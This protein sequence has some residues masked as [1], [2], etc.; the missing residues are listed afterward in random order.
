MARRYNSPLP[1]FM[2]RRI[3]PLFLSGTLLV[4]CA[5]AVSEGKVPLAE[6]ARIQKYPEPVVQTKAQLDASFAEWA[7]AARNPINFRLS[8]E[9]KNQWRELISESSW[10]EY[11]RRCTTAF[12]DTGQV[13][14]T[15]EYRD[16]VRL[17]A[18]WRDAAFRSSLSDAEESVLQFATQCVRELLRPGMSDFEKLLAIHDYLIQHS[19]YEETGANTVEHLLRKGSGSCEAYSAALSVMLEIAGI[20]VRVVTGN[21]GGPH[22]WNLVCIDKE[23]Y[24][25]DATWNDPLV[26]DGSRE[27]LSH[28]YFCLSDAEMARTHKWNCAAY[29]ASGKQTASYYRRKDIYF[30]SFNAFMRA[31]LCAY[32]RGQSC[33]E[34]YLTQYGS[35]E[36]FQR[37]LQR[38][39]HPSVPE[40]INWTGPDASAGAVIVSFGP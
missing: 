25:V 14:I 11:A 9:L 6:K 36:E 21:A 31:A 8:G 35:P 28:A 29:P 10:G 39:S 16:Y 27:V 23:W 13:S 3:I 1:A 19:R 7:R 18:A 20:P 38:F 4:Q 33:F 30:T 37:N 34:G 26:G 40:R 17:C 32:S 12:M 5:P 22:A 2:L 15:L 24:H